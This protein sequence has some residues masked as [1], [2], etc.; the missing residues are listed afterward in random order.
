MKL[1][2]ILFN[3]ISGQRVE[4]IKPG[5]TNITIDYLNIEK[6]K[7]EFLK[8]GE[9]IKISFNIKIEY[10]PHP[11][12][13]EKDKK[14][15]EIKFE[16]T[17]LLSAEKEEAKELMKYW[18]KKEVPPALK[19]ALFNSLIKRCTPKAIFLQEELNLPFHASIPQ[20]KAQ[21]AK[22]ASK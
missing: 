11:D 14:A 16:G 15:G 13:K 20:L 8:E 3:T 9:A 12:S 19:A 21:P 1:L 6:E 18:K 5:N 17:T 2:N 10:P 7:I 22:E 4:S